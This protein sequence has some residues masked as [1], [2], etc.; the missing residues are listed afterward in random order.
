MN[1]DNIIFVLTPSEENYRKFIRR[2]G[3]TNG[4][5]VIH[6]K[7]GRHMTGSRNP[8]LIMLPDASRTKHLKDIV[9]MYQISA[10]PEEEE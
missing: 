2:C 10:I 8:T 7:D 6:T 3:L 4:V 5:E 9:L 1:R